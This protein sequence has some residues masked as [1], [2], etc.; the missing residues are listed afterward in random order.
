MTFNVGARLALL[1]VVL[2]A[3]GVAGCSTAER[4][5]AESPTSPRSSSSAAQAT[6]AS[7]TGPDSTAI[8]P[9]DLITAEDLADVGEFE[10]TY[11]EGAGARTCD[12]QSGFESGGDGFAFSVG[13]RD[14]QG[15][16]SVR[17]IGGGVEP[18]TVNQRPAAKTYDPRSK[19][20]LIA[21]EISDTSRVD[22]TTL[23]DDGC[24]IAPIIA[25]LVEPKLPAVP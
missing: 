4:G 17:D 22:V 6:S 24:E 11:K 14:S 7:S 9:C 25:G 23:A 2:L 1:G 18:D 5:I 19:D 21:V 12:W 3:P 10:P 16:D 8:D 20:C 15:I 13:V